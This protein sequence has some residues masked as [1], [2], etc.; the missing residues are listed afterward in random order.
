MTEKQKEARLDLLHRTALAAYADAGDF[1]VFDWLT[2]KETKEYED[3]LIE[4]GQSSRE[5]FE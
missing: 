4:T 3:L 1:D 2:G 5:D